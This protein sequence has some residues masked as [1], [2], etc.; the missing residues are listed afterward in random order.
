MGLASLASVPPV[1]RQ[2]HSQPAERALLGG[3]FGRDQR[4]QVAR[5][6]SKAVPLVG[7][8]LRRWGGEA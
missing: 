1:D 7:E 2:P 8:L 3:V 4:G 5:G 6:A